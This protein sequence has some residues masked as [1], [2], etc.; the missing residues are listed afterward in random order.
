MSIYM[1]ENWKERTELLLGKEKI[2]TLQKSHILVVGLGGVGAYV[3]EQLARAGIGEMT[4]IDGDSVH[5]SN[6]NRQLL[7]LKSTQKQDKALLMKD[8]LLD[9]NPELKLH[10]INEYIKE[11]RIIEILNHPYDYIV[12]AIDTLSPKVSLLIESLEKNLPIIS[13]MGTGGKMD[14]SLIQIADISE[15]FNDNLARMIRKRLHK[16]GIYTGVK[17]VFSS[18]IINSSAVILVENE[19]NKRTTVG[20][21][22]YMPALFGNFISAVVIRDLLQIK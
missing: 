7:A 18:E 9:I 19:Q 2:N 20:T 3:A 14:P 21:I 6:L 16:K 17:V 4:I 13:S 10:V 22:S 1:V 11:D 8:R 15:S 12:D 5:S